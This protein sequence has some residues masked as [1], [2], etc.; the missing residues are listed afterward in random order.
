M[1]DESFWQ[2]SV[3]RKSSPMQGA[4]PKRRGNHAAATP[5]DLVLNMVHLD[6]TNRLAEINGTNDVN[7]AILRRYSCRLLTHGMMYY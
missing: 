3:N 7:Q 1:P 5:V 4:S 6:H 2:Y